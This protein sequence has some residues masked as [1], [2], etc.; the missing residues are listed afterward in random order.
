MERQRRRRE[1]KGKLG[2]KGKI[3]DYS[4]GYEPSQS[5]TQIWVLCANKVVSFLV[6]FS[7]II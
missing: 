2:Q 7:A 4:T 6:V 3:R 1:T 5:W